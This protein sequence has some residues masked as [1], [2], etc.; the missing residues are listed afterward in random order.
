MTQRVSVWFEMSCVMDF[1]FLYDF[2]KHALP[3]TWTT[4]CDLVLVAPTGTVLIT[5]QSVFLYPEPI[6]L[7]IFDL[8]ISELRRNDYY[9]MR[10]DVSI[11]L[12]EVGQLRLCN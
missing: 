4:F 8:W 3:T 10:V 6:Y 2:L 9:T 5:A 12:R 11:C 1:G 7:W